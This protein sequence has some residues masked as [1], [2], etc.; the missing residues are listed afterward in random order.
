MPLVISIHTS[1]E[2]VLMPYFDYIAI[3]VNEVKL[4]LYGFSTANLID[5]VF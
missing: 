3:Y 1:T 4:W 5:H 2:V